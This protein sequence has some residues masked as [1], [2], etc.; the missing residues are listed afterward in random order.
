MPA[1]VYVTV[2]ATT[3][4]TGKKRRTPIAV[5]QHDDFVS[6]EIADGVKLFVDSMDEVDEITG[7][8]IAERYR[9]L[10][11]AADA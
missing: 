3:S 6:I 9:L 11:Q 4:A 7:E 1:E 5:Y 10:G 2:H 8:L